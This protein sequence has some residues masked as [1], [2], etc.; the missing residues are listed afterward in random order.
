MSTDD[1]PPSSINGIYTDPNHPNG[2]RIVRV[3]DDFPTV[4]TLQDEPDGPIITCDGDVKTSSGTT[5]ITLD[6]SKKGGPKD[7][8]ATLGKDKLIFPDGN[9]WTKLGGVDGIYSDPFHP[10]GYRIVRIAE[11]GS[12]LN[13]TLQDKPDGKVILLEGARDETSGD[14][15]IDFSPKGYHK[16]LAATVKDGKVAFEDG[17]AWVKL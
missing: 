3:I 7:I 10:E 1:I 14:Y 6:L 4:V 2:Y 12:K 16:T 11:D 8:T 5:T 15:P 17:N 13:V 9:A